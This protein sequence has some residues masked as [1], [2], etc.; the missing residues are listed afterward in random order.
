[1]HMYVYRIAGNIGGDLNL[2]VWEATAKFKSSNFAYAHIICVLGGPTAKF[3]STNIFVWAAQD[4]TAKF[5]DR[6]YFWLY[7]STCTYMYVLTYMY[8]TLLV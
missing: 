8:M 7:G 2:V 6:Q 3:K 5:K 4:Q 1:M